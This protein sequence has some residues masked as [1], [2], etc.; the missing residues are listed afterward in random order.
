MSELSQEEVRE[1]VLDFIH[2]YS[3][4]HLLFTGG[5]ILAAYKKKGLPCAGRSF[6]N[7]FAT[8]V[9]VGESK[10]W[11]DKVGRK[12]PTTSQSHTKTLALWKSREHP[13]SDKSFAGT[14]KEYVENLRKRVVLEKYPIRDALWD[15]LTFG[16]ENS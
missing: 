9:T 11:Y 14:Q 12:V 5:D 2:A 15:A 13:D 4:E 16:M 1:I 7:W 10:Q 6:R 8:L 3:K